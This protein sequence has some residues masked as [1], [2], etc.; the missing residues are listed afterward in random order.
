M[1]ALK[2][3]VFGVADEDC[4]FFGYRTK[5]S[6]GQVYFGEVDWCRLITFYANRAWICRFSVVRE[7]KVKAPGLS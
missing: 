4:D 7:E 5:P 2:E 6:V 3:K 1:I